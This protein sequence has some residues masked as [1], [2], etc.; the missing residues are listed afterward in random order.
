MKG[1]VIMLLKGYVQENPTNPKPERSN[2]IEFPLIVSKGF[3]D[4]LTGGLKHPVL[5]HC[6]TYVEKITNRILEFVK[7][8]MFLT[9]EGRP[10]RPYHHTSAD[11]T[12]LVIVNVM[13]KDFDVL[14]VTRDEEFDRDTQTFKTIHYTRKTCDS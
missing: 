2:Y 10:S 5:Y 13:I 9:I 1:S 3:F 14:M 7:K 8:D 12:P 4:P 6:F 11:G